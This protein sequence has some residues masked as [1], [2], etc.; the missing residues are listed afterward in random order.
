ME[1][2]RNIALIVAACLIVVG[3]VGVVILELGA[4]E[5]R[6]VGRARDL[7]EVLLPPAL[8]LVLLVVIIARFGPAT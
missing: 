5:R 3:L 1:A 4:K 8:T 2:V 7:L 6:L